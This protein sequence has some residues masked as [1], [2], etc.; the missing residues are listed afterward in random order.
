MATQSMSKA[1]TCHTCQWFTRNFPTPA[2]PWE[3][4]V[5][6]GFCLKTE[7]SNGT[8]ATGGTLAIAQDQE[9]YQAIL[10]VNQSYG[11]VQHSPKE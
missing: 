8:T 7:S 5:D 1:E 9:G 6:S 3:C 11:C 2:F 4:P 10:Q